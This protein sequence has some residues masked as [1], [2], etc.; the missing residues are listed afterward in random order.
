MGW[1]DEFKFR[2]CPWCGL[3]DADMAVVAPMVTLSRPGTGHRFWTTVACPRCAGLVNIETNA[4]NENPPTLKA[5]A[6]DAPAG[7]GVDHLPEDVKNYLVGAVKVLD[8]GV[9][10]AAAVQLRRTL[11]AAAA[12]FDVRERTLVKSI[13]KLIELN[14]ITSQFGLVLN[15]VRKVGNIGA[16]AS[17]EAVDDD[18]ARRVL[19]FTLAVVR[20][21]FEIPAELAALPQ[22]EGPPPPVA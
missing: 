15:H 16:H 3:R 10:D 9:P 13:E 18:E 19:R 2:D 6:P 21:L 12:H 14:L 8:A 7:V 22:D 4:P 17:D 5:V 1:S 11:E 20:N